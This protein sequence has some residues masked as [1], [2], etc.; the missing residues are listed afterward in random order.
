MNFQMKPVP[1]EKKAGWDVSAEK[2]ETGRIVSVVMKSKYGTVTYGERPEGFDGWV[3]EESGGG[4]AVTLPFFKK[5]GKLYVGLLKESRLNMGGETLCI[6]GG[7]VDPGESHDQAQVREADEESDLKTEK[8]AELPGLPMNSNRLFFVADPK[9]GE[10]IHAYALGI[11]KDMVEER[12]GLI[13]FK[14]RFLS[15]HPKAKN[16][17]FMEWQKAI[18]ESADIIAL[19]TIGRLVSIA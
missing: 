11:H 18:A 7:F 1:T 3:F 13:V 14:E 19:A 16:V 5:D 6:M 15:I 10:G 9:K 8:A 2:D 4:G 12:D 17:I